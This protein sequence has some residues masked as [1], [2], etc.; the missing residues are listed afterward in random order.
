MLSPSDHSMF[1]F[2]VTQQLMFTTETEEVFPKTVK[3]L[4]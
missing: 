2:A 4:V 3:T 1:L